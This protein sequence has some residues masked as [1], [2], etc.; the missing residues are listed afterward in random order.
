MQNNLRF[1]YLL[2]SNIPPKTGKFFGSTR[3]QQCSLMWWHSPGSLAG[4]SKVGS[5]PPQ[6]LST[7]PLLIL[8]S[9]LSFLTAWQLDP[10]SA[11]FKRPSL[12]MQALMEPLLAWYLLMS[13][14]PR[15]VTWPG[16]NSTRE[17]PTPGRGCGEA[18]CIRGCYSNNLA[19]YT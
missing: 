9:S 1:Y 15:Q 14:W 12:N 19:Q 2:L 7:W 16:P 11:N 5:H 13:P 6:P 17:G 10:K 8:W 18:R 4:T 3:H